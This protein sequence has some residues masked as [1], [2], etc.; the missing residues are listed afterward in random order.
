MD[1]LT[2]K[3]VGYLNYLNTRTKA[4][5]FGTKIQ[6]IITALNTQIT[7]IVE[8][9]P[10]NAANAGKILTIAGV[11][12]DGETVTINNPAT[13]GTDVYEFLADAAQ[14]KTAP[15]NIA[16]DIESHTT[17]ASRTLTLDTQPVSGNTM[18][19]GTKVFTFVPVGTATADGEISVGADLAGAQAA[20]VAA[21]NGTDGI[22]DPHPL[23]SA[24]DFA[25]NFCIFTALVGGVAGDS[26]ATTETFTAETNIFAGGTLAGGADCS[27]TNAVTELVAAFTASD[28]QGVGAVDG[29]GDTVE[30][31]ADLAGVI[32]NAIIIGKVMANATFA[33]GAT[34]LSGGVNATLGALGDT[35]IDNTYLYHC[36]AAN[37]IADKNWRRF[38][39]GAAY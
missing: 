4:M 22:N 12:K 21:V 19:I 13:T 37:T 30:L 23:A 16:V 36:V 26:V 18:T 3:Q 32:G 34:L 2:T 31:T 29:N 7:G 24:G 15:T 27:A 39:L 14:T 20:L 33:G 28:T 10:V 35:Q 5:G 11:V 38:S 25:G 6:E 1:A 9:T 8:G 17:K